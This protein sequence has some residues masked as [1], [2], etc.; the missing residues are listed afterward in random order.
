MALASERDGFWV[1]VCEPS[2]IRTATLAGLIR[3]GLFEPS[4][5]P[6]YTGAGWVERYAQLWRFRRCV[7]D[8]HPGRWGAAVLC[9][10]CLALARAGRLEV[11]EVQEEFRAADITLD[12]SVDYL[13]LLVEDDGGVE[14]LGEFIVT[15]LPDPVAG[16]D[17][18]FDTDLNPPQPDSGIARQDSPTE[19]V[20]ERPAPTNTTWCVSHAP[21]PAPTCPDPPIPS[22]TPDD[23]PACTSSDSVSS[24]DSGSG[25]SDSGG[26]G[27]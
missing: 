14:V 19:P 15:S 26:S 24:G 1:K 5:P 21:A 8:T 10:D 18:T 22:Y 2:Q 4:M 25:S 7:V 11:E 3:S 16:S 12:P 9:A 13:T 6:V 27:D 23:A 17:S 20:E